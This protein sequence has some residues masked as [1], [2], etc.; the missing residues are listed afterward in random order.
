M[1]DEPPDLELRPYRAEDAEP[2]WAAFRAAITR[3]ASADYDPGQI[4]AWAGPDQPD[5][6]DWQHRRQTAHTVVAV[7]AGRVVGFS[8]FRD[9]GVLD[10][11][12]V[13]PDAGGHGVARALVGWVRAAAAEAGLPGLRTYA[14]RTA[15]PVFARLGFVVVAERPDNR[16]RGRRLPNTEMWCAVGERRDLG[17]LGPGA[18]SP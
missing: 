10:M 16:V 13:H 9:D 11:L 4:A 17:L 18:P 15:R 12:F 5:L 6:L 3:T 14:S 1:V 7:L 8:D 2:T